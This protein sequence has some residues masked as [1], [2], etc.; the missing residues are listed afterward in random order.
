MIFLRLREGNSSARE[1]SYSYQSN[2]YGTCAA[3]KTMYR[4]GS[5][6]ICK[7]ASGSAKVRLIAAINRPDA[8]SATGLSADFSAVVSDGLGPGRIYLD[9]VSSG[10]AEGQL[11][12]R[13]IF[14]VQY[15]S[16]ALISS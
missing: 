3:S 11:P 5:Q 7:V 16:R 2:L 6:R 14:R 9:N 13:L 1:P 12:D 15:W 4:D 8:H 10:Y